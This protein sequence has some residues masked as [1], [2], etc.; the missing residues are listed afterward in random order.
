MIRNKT[1]KDFQFGIIDTLEPKSLPR[2]AASDSLNFLTKVDRIA[3]RN[4][5]KLYGNDTAGI[6]KI[7]GLFF[8]K[9]SDGTEIK[10]RTHGQKL[11]YYVSATDTWTEIGTNIL[12]AGADGKDM[13]FAEWHPIAGDYVYVNSPYGPFIKIDL[14]S[15]TT[16]ASVYNVAKN[17]YGYIKIKQNR[18]WLWGR[19]ADK[20]GVYISKI[21]DPED[22]TY[23]SPRV[24]AEG[25]IFRQ[26]DGGPVQTIESFGEKEYCMHT[27]K[28]WVIEIT[29]DDTNAT[30]LIYRDRVG[31]SNFRGAVSTADGIYYVD[32]SD[33]ADPQI[34]LLTIPYGMDR[35]IPISVSKA[36]KYQNTLVGVDLSGYYFDKACGIE[37]EDYIIFSFRTTDSTQNNTML[38]FNKRQKSID[39]LNYWASCLAVS[40]GDLLGGDPVENNVIQFFSGYSDESADITNYWEGNKDDLDW[41]GEKKLK[42]LIIKGKIGIEQNIKMSAYLDDAVATELG[43]I[44][45]SSSSVTGAGIAV[46]GRTTIGRHEVGGGGSGVD[47]AEFISEIDVS[48]LL[49]RFNEI[50][51]R[52]EATELGVAEISEIIY[53]DFRLKSQKLISRFR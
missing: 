52:I 34:R 22:F 43:T 10:F 9:K 50:K 41:P 45:G 31:I 40:S 49:D 1:I 15:P 14:A 46:V 51:L 37:F 2:G 32:D 4:G 6:G 35:V 11:E 24:A 23:S 8:A 28:T 29:A 3:L 16:A 30:N 25:Q 18:M 19:T 26:D 20:T 47:S 7:T 44:S 33:K 17:Y 39:I 12:G 53:K 27:D 48:S 38:L 36:R 13:S 42:R 21:N 5:Y